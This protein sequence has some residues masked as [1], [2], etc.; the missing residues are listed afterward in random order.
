MSGWSP[1]F[2]GRHPDTHSYM[3]KNWKNHYVD[4]A[5][6]H[7]TGTVHGWQSILLYPDIISIF[8]EEFNRMIRRWNVDI[9]G[10]VIMPEHF[11]MLLRSGEGKDV[12]RFIQG[13]RRYVS[14]RV[15]KIIDTDNNSFRVYCSTND[16]DLAVFYSKTGGK[17]TFRFWKEKPRVFPLSK[18]IDI[19]KKLDYIHNNPV[20]RGLVNSPDEW[21]YSS[22][23]FYA[24]EQLIKLSTGH[25]RQDVIDSI[26]THRHKGA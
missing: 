15:R 12:M 21:E 7:V 22:F 11:H 4:H 5:V 13:G 1:I 3:T 23:R 17:S 25:E 14:G 19:Q 10:F 9:I 26:L 18:E 20:R 6:H 24:D 16:I 8:E 2:I